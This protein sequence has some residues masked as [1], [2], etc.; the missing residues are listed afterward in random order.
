[1]LVCA[2]S[3]EQRK[4][5]EIS[6]SFEYG[7][8][9]AAT[10]Y[11]GKHKYIRITDIDD[12]THLFIQD[13]L[14]SP[15]IDFSTAD[16]YLL[17]AG[18]VL[19]ART[20]ASVGKTYIYR[21]SDGDLYFA[22]FLIR[23][24]IKRDY[25]ADFVFQNTLTDNYDSYIRITS[26]RSGQ[27]GVNA[28]EYA[29]FAL[30]VP[31]LAEQKKIGAYFTNLD[32]LI[33]LHQRECFSFDFGSR[34]AKVAQKTISWEQRKL[35]EYLTVSTKKN[36]EDKYDKTD[37]LSV[38]GEVGVVN[39]IEFQGRSFAGASVSNYGVV[40]TGDVVYTK[41][42]LRANPYGII[43]ANKGKSGIV[44]T[45]YAVYKTIQGTANADFIECYFDLDDR[46]NMYLKPLVNIGAKHDMKVTDENAL[47]GGVLF[48]S[49]EEQ[50]QIADF[51]SRL[52]TLITLHQREPP[53]EDKILNDIKTDTLFHEYY[54]QWLVIYKE[55]SV[56]GVT[57]QKYHLT[58][59]WVK[60]LI[61]DVK[62]C[63]FDRITYQQ[64]INDYAETHERQTTM[65]FHHQLKGAILDAVDDGL[66]ARDPTRKVI[67]K[68]KSP[69]DKK[70]KY[71]SRYELQ[72]LL[73]SLDLNSGLNMDWLIL[74]IAKTGMRFS[75]AIAVTPMDFDFTHQTLSVN[76]TWD[77]KGEGGF[78]PT[79][80]KSS[81]RKIRLDWQ[82][83]G[84]FY[85]IVREL[86][87]TAPIFVSKEKKIYN[88]TLNDVLE[89]HCKAV[90][91]PT[92][93]V[94]GLRH[95]HAS[96][97]LFDGVSIASV[98]Q[99]LGHS[100]INTTQ[101]TYLHIIRELENKDIDL[102]MKSISS[103]LD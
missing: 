20:G 31:C 52:D 72:K 54:C 13:N 45:L 19:F 29:N 16:D 103:L 4:L 53:K 27:P 101:K 92:I 50:C 89:R 24:K 95:T 79:K 49:Y 37:V 62:L 88:S 61:P 36:T 75:E 94:H 6:E 33:T 11:D 3:W 66:I 7:L 38:S 81:V 57:M 93:S 40:E 14:T 59:E 21:S 64:L 70:K 30:S 23:A 10:E 26:Q 9:A 2:F 91:I 77:Y 82:T 90:G 87:D 1:M 39:Q 73:T 47:K 85:A 56:R 32:N 74:L 46:L 15:D 5:G 17:Q 78:Q 96:L 44:S 43:K 48:P 25:D 97:L 98:A 35:N 8:N 65:D 83:V 22:G 71:L 55:G 100:S 99:R 80:N 34:S 86:N 51:F 42:P 84:Q 18:D 69:N 63:D 41:S 76:K 102:I 68:G 28:Q 12:S 67:I 58:A 60:K